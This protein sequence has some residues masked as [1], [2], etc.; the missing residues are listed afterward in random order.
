MPL[1]G[2]ITQKR[3]PNNP[4]FGNQYTIDASS[5]IQALTIADTIVAG[6][7]KCHSNLVDFIKHHVWLKGG[8]FNSGTETLLSGTGEISATEAIKSEIVCRV[9][10]QTETGKGG[11]KDFRFCGNSSALSGMEWETTV[12]ADMAE[13]IGVWSS[14]LERLKVGNKTVLAVAVDSEYQFHQL[15]PKW[16]NRA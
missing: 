9:Y 8:P 13:I 11:Y 14:I 4:E 1:Y 6:E 5:L 2:C 15:S 10:L 3:S 12:L 7:K 16:Y